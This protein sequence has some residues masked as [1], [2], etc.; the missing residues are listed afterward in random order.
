MEKILVV[1]DE[2]IILVSIREILELYEYQVITASN[3]REAL[4]MFGLHNPDLILCDVMMPELDGYEFLS[5]L[6][7]NP[8]FNIPFIFL[9]AKVQSEDIRN[10]MNLGADDYIFKPFKS[11]DLLNAI[12]F[13]L[14]KKKQDLE[15][16]NT[17]TR[18][19][20]S[21]V[22]LMI[23]HEFNTPMNGIMNISR[24]ITGKIDKA[25]DKELSE[26]CKHLTD[27]SERLHSTFDK[28]KK[29]F[30]LQENGKTL[31]QKNEVC[32][33]ADLVTGVSVSIAK[34][35]GRE[36]DLMVE[37]IKEDVLPI[38]D[39]HM[40]SAIYEIIEN[41]FKF[42][43]QGNKVV[44]KTFIENGEY[45]II[46]SNAGNTINAAELKTYKSFRQFNRELNGQQGLGVGLA[47]TKKIVEL[48][49]GR[50]TISDN[51]PDGISVMLSFKL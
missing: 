34:K 13:R 10:G 19:L 23:G 47:I 37:K 27:S 15:N 41:A 14:A 5:L 50:I 4:K 31:K 42:S 39:H 48:Y 38:N 44:I 46:V 9:T 33:I 35:A 1:E 43:K 36:A 7:T 30:E 6:K 49:D 24:F 26:F 8:D 20:E 21:L 32:N 18:D 17:K 16:V 25:N 3:G 45:H 28:V 51:S 40:F 2:N 29:L 11:N 22:K 12:K